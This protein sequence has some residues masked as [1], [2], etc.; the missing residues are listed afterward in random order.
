MKCLWCDFETTEKKELVTE[1][2]KYANLEHIF[3]ECVG[4][5][6][7][8][9]RGKVCEDCNNR[10]GKTDEDLKRQNFMMMKQ[11]QDSS[12][13]LISSGSQKRPIG[14][15]GRD[16]EDKE[17]KKSEML[18][19]L[20]YSGGTTVKR[21]PENTNHTTLLN[22]QDG[23]AG[24][25]TYN[26]KFSKALH[27]CAIN[28]L[29]D[30][31]DYE[32]LKKNHKDLIGFVNNP[33]NETYNKWSYAICYAD[34]FSKVHFEPF[35]LQKIEVE[36]IVH[37]VVLIFPCAIFIVCTKPNIVTVD[38]LN[39]VGLNPPKLKNWEESGFD[40]LKHF[41]NGG[42]ESS[43]KT[44]GDKFKFTLIKH[45]ISGEPNPEDSFF[46]LTKCKTCGQTNPTGIM[47]NK[48]S[49]LNGKQNH[50]TGGNRNTWNKLS[51]KDLAKKG[52]IVEKWSEESLQQ[53]I[54]QGVYY[55][56]END[57]KK[58][59]IKE[60]HYQCFNCGERNTYDASDCFV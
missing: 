52:L 49:I 5:K 40:Y 35:C 46:L 59:N 6:K 2:T 21:N 9:E 12:E 19:I 42:F 34:L 25:V 33:K 22:L 47:L 3:P 31:H 48:E 10:L 29:L 4:G 60:C 26:T 41:E 50:T 30:E 53:Q 55:P 1:T 44:F 43:R 17:R 13:V 14:K 11:Y 32:Y 36:S 38:L 24:D 51:I 58:M 8:L 39:M 37:T 28:V 56:V 54:D 27:K 7:T 20:G 57:V 18:E 23:S 16:K 15:K 45:E